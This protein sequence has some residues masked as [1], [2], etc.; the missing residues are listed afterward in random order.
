MIRV[1]VSCWD[2]ELASRWKR[3]ALCMDGWMDG[4]TSKVRI[5]DIEILQSDV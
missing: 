2:C 1:V 3:I 4:W 5:I